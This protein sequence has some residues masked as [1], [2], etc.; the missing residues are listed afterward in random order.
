MPEECWLSYSGLKSLKI[1]RRRVQSSCRYFE[2]LLNGTFKEG[3][4]INVFL[5]LK[6]LVSYEAFSHVVNYAS[7]GTFIADPDSLGHHIQA[8]QLCILWGYEDFMRVL[9]AHLIS[10]ISY[11][12]II[13][14]HGLAKRHKTYL[15]NL[16]EACEKFKG[17][18]VWNGLSTESLGF[19]PKNWPVC[20]IE[21]HARH[22]ASYC[23]HRRIPD[24]YANDPPEKEVLVL[25][26]SDL[27]DQQKYDLAEF[28]DIKVNRFR[29]TTLTSRRMIYRNTKKL[30]EESLEHF[31]AVVNSS[32]D[33][34][35]SVIRRTMYRRGNALVR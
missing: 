11:S 12:T 34:R 2:L 4:E 14:I 19:Y 30:S 18:I 26:E 22:H 27:T 13:Y 8:V 7:H 17:D 9:E 31:K 6:N 33:H 24:Q 15:T 32:Q 21:G 29:G 16:V 1:N 3:R 20:A 35:W 23:S 25:F 28:R 10:Q 5:E